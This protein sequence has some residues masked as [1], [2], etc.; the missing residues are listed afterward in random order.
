MDVP[1]SR[2]TW[3]GDRSFVRASTRAL[4]SPRG[5]NK[6]QRRI[7]VGKKKREKDAEGEGESEEKGKREARRVDTG[8]TTIR[9]S[10]SFH[11]TAFSSLIVVDEDSRKFQS[12]QFCILLLFCLFLPYS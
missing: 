3:F 6:K 2:L 1:R 7:E 9:V 10:V 11:F 5:R 12:I 8:R 4:S